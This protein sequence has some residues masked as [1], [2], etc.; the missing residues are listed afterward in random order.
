MIILNS[1]YF[2]IN[3][4][5]IRQLFHPYEWTLLVVS[6]SILNTYE[7]KKKSELDRYMIK[8]THCI[9]HLMLNHSSYDF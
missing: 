7:I 8:S 5:K 6:I 9:L 3:T 2:H 4:I 1:S